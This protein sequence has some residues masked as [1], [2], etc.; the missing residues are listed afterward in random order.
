[1]LLEPFN[2]LAP[3]TPGF[4]PSGIQ[5]GNLS[6]I[7]PQDGYDHAALVLT[8]LATEPKKVTL[9]YTN[10]TAGAPELSIY[11]VPFVKSAAM[12]YVADP[13][14]PTQNG[15]TLRPGE[16]RMLFVSAKGKSVGKWQS[17]L[18]IA[19]GDT[20]TSLTVVSQVLNVSMPKES[21]L[22]VTNWGYLDFKPIRNCKS[23]AVIDMFD[24]HTN[25]VVVPTWYIPFADSATAFDFIKL[26]NY[27][28]LNNGASKVMFFLNFNSSNLLTANNK[29]K[30]M[31]A[32]WKDWFKK[33][34]VG[35]L[36][37][38]NRSGFSEDQ[39]FVY[40]FDEMHGDDVDRFIALS[41][42]A[43]KEIPA[44]KFYATL[45]R[46]ES[47]R[48]L[49]CVD[50]AQV[51]N[52]NDMYA[53]AINSKKEIWMYGATDNT[54]SLS[55]YSY[56]RLM[57]W[58]AFTLGFNGAGFWNYADTGSGENPGTAWD[59]FDGKR[60]DFAV[61][62]E[63]EGGTIVSSRR[64]EAWRMGVEDYELLRMYAKTRGETAAKEL[65]KTILDNPKDVGKADEVRH[66]IMRELSQ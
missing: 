61:I 7:S 2:P 65:A 40:P 38:A 6:F 47:L 44:I 4:T 52:R 50:I 22:N 26:D 16:S 21:T 36:Y 45:E 59:D 25:V 57:P 29:Y 35:M 56:F 48:A 58:N 18:K 30:F 66:N 13:L 63:G 43:H 53:E 41:S 24:H 46:K 8:N 62:Y 5:A 64:W 15:F 17:N 28:K 49:P 12:E 1:M 27:L 33:L 11:H 60:P 39:L 37:S 55:P 34:Y 14:V 19:C 31:S 42:W 9:A 51:I 32:G 3:L 23:D 10:G 54:K 20:V